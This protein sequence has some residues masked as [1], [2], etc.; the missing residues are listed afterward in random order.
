MNQRQIDVSG[1]ELL[2]YSALIAPTVYK[3]MSEIEWEKAKEMGFLSP[4]KHGRLYFTSDPELAVWYARY[5]AELHGST[6]VVVAFPKPP[7]GQ[8][9]NDEYGLT[10]G[11]EHMGK[12][13]TEF[14]ITFSIPIDKVRVIGTGFKIRYDSSVYGKFVYE[15]SFHEEPEIKFYEH[16]VFYRGQEIPNAVL[17]EILRDQENVQELG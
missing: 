3:G 5:F 7:S 9:F 13:R 2:P 16:A 10:V 8:I 14:F 17:K 11:N 15:G 4:G 1:L 6:G 12:F